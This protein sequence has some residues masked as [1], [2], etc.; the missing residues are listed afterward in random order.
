MPPA[1]RAMAT[2]STAS[3]SPPNFGKNVAS[4][5]TTDPAI[6]NGWGARGYNWEY[7]ISGQ[8]ELAPRVSVSGGWF[9]RS[10]LPVLPR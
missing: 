3:P 2:I 8:H 10:W 7:A 1:R 9:R 6:L 4:T 5:L